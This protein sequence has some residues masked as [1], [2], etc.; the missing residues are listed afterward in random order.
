MPEATKITLS[1]QERQLLADTGWILTKRSLT[2]KVYD[3]FGQLSLRFTQILDQ[4]K[5]GLP[6]EVVSSEP[7]I[8]KGENYREFPYVMLDHPRC[9]HGQDSFAIR[10]FFWWGQFF[11]LALQLSG[12]Y[13]KAFEKQ[14]LQHIANGHAGNFFLC[15]AEDPWQHHF[16]P[17]NYRAMHTMSLAEIEQV[18]RQHDFCKMALK[19]S[20]EEWDELPGLMEHG[21][22]SILGLLNT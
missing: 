11:S 2:G 6:P 4:Q 7:K 8:Y 17:D 20:V 9:F 12:S 5:D 16:Q 18:F 22:V 15:V 1:P 3:L 21:F 13:K 10:S 19:F 14:L